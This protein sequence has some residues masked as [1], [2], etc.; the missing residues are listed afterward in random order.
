MLEKLAFCSIFLLILSALY[1]LAFGCAAKE[2][3][4]NPYWPPPRRT[5]V[6]YTAEWCGPCRK[7]KPI[8]LRLIGEG[9]SVKIVDIDAHHKKAKR[10]GVKSVPTFFVYENSRLVL[11]TQ[12]VYAAA[13]MLWKK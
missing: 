10:A 2:P 13:K 9:W 1:V 5:M 7:A 3:E 6:A 11:R 12:N 8:L 4:A